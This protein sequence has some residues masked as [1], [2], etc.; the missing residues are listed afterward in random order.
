[1]NT[2]RSVADVR[3]ALKDVPHPVGLV[4]TM[5]ALHEGH[6]EL[7]RTAREQCATVVVSLF[8]NPAQFDDDADL[9]AY[10]RDEARDAQ[11]ARD[12]GADLLFAPPQSEVY[13]EGFGTTVSLDGALTTTLE[14]AHRGKAHFDGVATVVT[15]LFLMVQPDAAYF[16]QKDAQ[17]LVVIRHLVRDLD[18][19]VRIEAV[20]TVREHDGL[21]LSSRN[22]HLSESDRQKAIALNR[23]LH[24][25]IQAAGAGERDARA[26]REQAIETM[27]RFGVEPEYLELGDPDD[28]APVERIDGDV[29]VAVA[30][31]VGGTRLIDNTLIHTNGR[32]S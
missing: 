8:V 9:A 22:V 20:P 24:T 6:L 5:G 13:P 18:L 10:P 11:L 16:G 19:P 28:L 4:P 15:K 32:P 23:A 29:L 26:V 3:A 30:A 31:R 12:A 7:I 21:A 14:G 1:M 17:Q 25:A 2:V 27:T